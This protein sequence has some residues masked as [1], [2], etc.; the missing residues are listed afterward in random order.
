MFCFSKSSIPM[1]LNLLEIRRFIY[2]KVISQINT[3]LAHGFQSKSLK[4]QSSTKTLDKEQSFAV[5]TEKKCGAHKAC[6][7]AGEHDS[8]ALLHEW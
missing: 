1:L 6:K 8:T 3:V 2:S 4:L 7:A 5:L